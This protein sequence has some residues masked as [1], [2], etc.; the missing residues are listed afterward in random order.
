[1]RVIQFQNYTRGRSIINVPS[2][3]V[4]RAVGTQSAK[5]H[6]IQ[7]WL[8]LAASDYDPLAKS[9]RRDHLNRD[10]FKAITCLPI[11]CD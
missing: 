4:F 7:S 11:L 3:L 8:L 6:H 5:T 9:Q 1:V 10:D 2:V